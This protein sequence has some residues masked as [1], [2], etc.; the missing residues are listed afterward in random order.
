M[1]A[2]VAAAAAEVAVLAAVAAA[3]VAA[4]RVSLAGPASSSL[5][6]V[7][8]S[9]AEP[10][11][12]VPPEVQELL[13]AE[14]SRRQGG[15]PSIRTASARCG[16]GNRERREAPGASEASDE[17]G[18]AAPAS[19]RSDATEAPAAEKPRRRPRPAASRPRA[20][21]ARRPDAAD[22]P[23]A[24]K[25]RKTATRR[26]RGTASAAE[27]PHRTLTRPPRRSRAKATTRRKPA[28]SATRGHG[29]RRGL[30]PMSASPADWAHGSSP[31][32]MTRPS[33]R[34]RGSSSRTG[35]PTASSS[36]GRV[37]S[38]RRRWRSTWRPACSASR[39]DATAR[40][41]RACSACRKVAA[42]DHPGRAPHRARGCRRPDPHRAGSASSRWTLSLLAME[43]RHR[44]AIMSAAQRM[45]P[46]A[47]NALLKTLEEP[48]PGHLHRPVRRRRWRRLLPTVLSRVGAPAPRVH[49]PLERLTDLLVERGCRTAGAGARARDRRRR[50]ARRRA[51]AGA[52]SP[53]P[54]WLARRIVAHAPRPRYGRPAHA[55]RGERGPPGGRDARGR[56]ARG[57]SCRRPSAT[58]QAAERRRA[59]LTVIAAWRDLARD[60][61]RR[62]A[63]RPVARSATATCS[64]TCGSPRRCRPGRAA[65]ASSTGSTRCRQRWRPTPAPR[66]SSMSCSSS[67]LDA[68]PGAPGSETGCR[69]THDR[70]SIQPGTPGAATETGASVLGRPPAPRRA[71]AD[72]RCARASSRPSAAP[73]RAS[74]SASSS[75][76]RQRGLGL[77]GWVANRADGSV[78]VVAEGRGADLDRLVERL[79]R[80]RRARACAASTSARN[81]P[82]ASLADSRSEAASTA[83]TDRAMY[84]SAMRLRTSTTLPLTAMTTSAAGSSRCRSS[85]VPRRT[86]STPRRHDRRARLRSRP[87]DRAPGPGRQRALHRRL[88]DGADRAGRTTELAR[89]GPGDFFGE[90][91]VIDQQPRTAS[92]Y[93]VG[94]DDLP[95]PRLVGPARDARA[96]PAVSRSTCSRSSPRRLRRAD[97]QLR[98]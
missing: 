43:G 8:A 13:R 24:E 12:E 5:P 65:A 61:A 20:L 55:P 26:K 46:D 57:A 9:S 87:A 76:A 72:R 74:A 91:S 21:R 82:A 78:E 84:R 47:Q 10:W 19:R 3:P 33:R 6:S 62:D 2:A 39:P 88:G 18:C 50:S 73:S 86:C 11:S 25:P 29:Q 77:D 79:G 52:A 34:W 80:D 31:R 83:A 45:N 49:S 60:L 69:M 67:G 89:L 14:V 90:L 35:P 63:R 38:A 37:G 81:R 54:S 58:L 44:V 1:V 66:S 7:R 16:T 4:H 41:C 96:R 93:A 30:T 53:T 59:A 17:L 15:S 27:V 23:A 71:A 92:A 42:G 40:P 94:C 22:A 32:A 51:R 48:G 75:I 68:D 36:R 98:H 28:A 97:E 95:D 85:A 64:T 70:P 56:R